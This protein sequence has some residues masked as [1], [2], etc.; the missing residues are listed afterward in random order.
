MRALSPLSCYASTTTSGRRMFNVTNEWYAY[1]IRQEQEDGPKPTAANTLLR[2]SDAGSCERQRGFNAILAKPT[3]RRSAETLMA[4]ELG[5]AIHDSLQAMML[6]LEDFDTQVEVPVDLSNMVSLSG[7]C[8]AFM[9]NKETGKSFVVEIKT[10]SGFGAVRTFHGSPKREHVAQAGLYA[11]GLGADGI[12]IVY[13]AKEAAYRKTG[14]VRPGEIAQWYYE[15]D[16]EVYPDTSVRDVVDEELV[17]FQ[18]VQIALENQMLPVPIAYSD[19]SVDFIVD[20]PGPFGEPSKHH[21]WECRY[22]VYNSACVQVGPNAVPLDQIE[23]LE[24]AER[25]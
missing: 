23:V 13:V 9:V 15:M 8:D 1:K 6:E 14:G 5:N 18:R 22:C 11:E 12:L 25:N 19:D 2:C 4:F 24:I 16:E 21:H 17:R 3:E 7:S 10:M 20:F